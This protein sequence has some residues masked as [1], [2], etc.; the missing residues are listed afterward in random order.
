MNN[1]FEENWQDLIK[2]PEVQTLIAL[3]I[4]EDIGSGDVTSNAIFKKA[5]SST[6]YIINRK[7]TVV[8]GLTV[9]E[10][11]FRYFDQNIQFIKKIKDGDLVAA[12]TVLCEITGDIKTILT[13]ERCALN[14]LMR[15]CGVANATA[16]AVAA[17]PPFS[18]T[19]IY[20]TRKTTPGWRRLDKAA[21]RVGGGENHR[22]GLFD[23]VLIKDNH[24]LAAGS[25]S[26]AV[27]QARTQNKPNMIVEV[28]IDHLTQ[29]DEAISAQPDIILLDNF[30]LCDMQKA[31]SRVAGRVILEA[32][33]GITV[34]QVAAIA[35]TGIDRIS[36]GS[37]THSALPIDLS[38]EIKNELS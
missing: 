28:E 33:G 32:S 13:A 10:I 2:H 7:S 5:Q 3:A 12:N 31:V 35:N 29:L 27:K 15:L 36:M 26:L 1:A 11:I 6:A 22:M 30:S 8:A 17:L 23:A 18:K 19:R 4:A 20:D 21:V 37:L 25:L 9:A 38:L 16:T 24:I 34:E 14:F